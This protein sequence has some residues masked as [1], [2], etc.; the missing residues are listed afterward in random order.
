M[1]KIFPFLAVSAILATSAAQ[2]QNYDYTPYIGADYAY[3]QAHAQGIKPV[4]HAASVNLGSRY[5]DYFGTELFYTQTGSDSKKTSNGKYKSS[6]RGYG[7][8]MA[9]YL[10]LG[11]EQRFELTASIGL[12]EYVFNKKIGNEK[13]HN[14]SGFGYR[15]GGGFL[16]HLSG[17]TAFRLMA[18]HIETDHISGYD[19]MTEYLAGLRYYF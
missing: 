15:F 9:A 4:Y 1:T 3:S 18:R 17:H 16:Y 19:H 13:H 10:P 11:C 14:D 8:D 6:Y 2:A 12:G 5:N 7:L